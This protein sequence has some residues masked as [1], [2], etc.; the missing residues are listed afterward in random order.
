M[1]FERDTRPTGEAVSRLIAADWES[2]DSIVQFDS[3]LSLD[4]VGGSVFL[5]NARVFLGDLAAN[6]ADAT[7]RGN[8]CRAFVVRMVSD[9]EY[10]P[11]YVEHLR[12]YVK[13]MNEEEV[14]DLHILRVVCELAGLVGRRKGRFYVPRPRRALL[15]D[16]KA[17]QLFR[18]LFITYFRSMDLNYLHRAREIPLLQDGV[19][20]ML[21]ILRDVADDF[22]PVE[23][24]AA[25]IVPPTVAGVIRDCGPRFDGVVAWAVRNMFLEPLEDFGLLEVLR[26]KDEDLVA[27]LLAVRKSPLF[28]RF[29]DIQA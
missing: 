11:G 23:D 9:L 5:R 29:I 14:G 15:A 12:R 3:T 10:P 18:S 2:P 25:K 16:E 13:A 22:I 4:E 24:L 28:D 26:E 17:G 8:L 6:G 27:P 19:A 7:A 1:I 20:V 21:R